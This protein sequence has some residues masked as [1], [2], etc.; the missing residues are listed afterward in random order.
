MKQSVLA[1]LKVI[2][3]LP[4]LHPYFSFLFKKK[5][6]LRK[7]RKPGHQNLVLITSTVQVELSKLNYNFDDIRT[8]FLQALRDCQQIAFAGLIRF[9]PLLTEN[10][11]YQVKSNEKY[12]TFF[13]IVFQVLKHQQIS[14]FENF[15]N[16]IQH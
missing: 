15:Q 7:S 2:A 8:Y 1:S 12:I 3:S 4:I 14:F 10:I 6:F 13:Y 9:C 11:E 5:R 16:F